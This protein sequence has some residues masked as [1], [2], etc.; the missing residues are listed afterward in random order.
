MRL[1]TENI[2]MSLWVSAKRRVTLACDLKN[3][4]KTKEVKVLHRI[5]S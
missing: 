3:L 2:E 5:V 1:G 4:S